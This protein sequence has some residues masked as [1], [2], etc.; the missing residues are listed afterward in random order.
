M[1]VEE[2]HAPD[3]RVCEIHHQ[4]NI[5]FNWDIDRVKPFG[6]LEPHSVLG[7]N[8]E[9]NLMDVKRV[10]LVRA[11]RDSPVMKS[12]DGY[13]CH[14]WIRRTVFSA[15]DIESV[16]VLGEINDKVR[17][18]IF[19]PLDQSRGQGFGNWQSGLHWRG[20]R[21]GT[22]LEN[23]DY[24]C[25]YHR[26]I[27]VSIASCIKA[28][29][30]QCRSCSGLGAGDDCFHPSCRRK[31]N[32]GS[33]FNGVP[34]IVECQRHSIEGNDLKWFSVDLQVSIEVGRSILN[35]PE[36]ALSGTDGD[37]RA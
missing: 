12:S 25:Q 31:E 32:M 9:V 1:A 7:I 20:R 15:I 24:V 2:R 36:L 21:H 37:L 30:S 4:I 26:R 6:T 14:G 13:S 17:R 5:T 34:R 3:D 33:K 8:E 16:L 23:V 35:S 19:Y 18:G 29:C 22:W 10:H 11:I 27:R 28:T